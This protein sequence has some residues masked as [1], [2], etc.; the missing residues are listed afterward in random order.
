MPLSIHLEISFKLTYFLWYSSM[1][2]SNWI[3]FYERYDDI[4]QF[5]FKFLW[6][7]GYVWWLLVKLSND[8]EYHNGN[9]MMF[10]INIPFLLGFQ[11]HF[12][13]VFLYDAHHIFHIMRHQQYNG[14]ENDILFLWLWLVAINIFSNCNHALSN[15]A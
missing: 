7:S 14:E 2:K 3:T 6:H 4:L 9:A 12:N 10:V 15:I 13:V 8:F 11:L 1:N 5:H